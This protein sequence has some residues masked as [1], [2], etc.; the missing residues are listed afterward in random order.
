MFGLPCVL[1]IC[2]LYGVLCVCCLYFHNLNSLYFVDQKLEAAATELTA[3][4]QRHVEAMA[5]LRQDLLTAAPMPADSTVSAQHDQ[6]HQSASAVSKRESLST[7][8]LRQVL[9]D[10]ESMYQQHYRQWASQQ[11]YAT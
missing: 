8:E 1:C 5:E 3:Q 10:Q 4:R 11:R 7:A 6:N 9:L 2:R